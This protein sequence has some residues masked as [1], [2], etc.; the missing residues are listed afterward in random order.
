ME[1]TIKKID[2]EVVEVTDVI[3]ETRVKKFS[4]SDLKAELVEHQQRINEINDI[5][6]VVS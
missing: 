6:K 3:T 4:V 2:D 5:L 1:R